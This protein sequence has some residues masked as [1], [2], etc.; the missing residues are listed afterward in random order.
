MNRYEYRLNHLRGIAWHDMLISSWQKLLIKY[1]NVYV[2]DTIKN[3]Q[4]ET[5]TIET[6]NE[7]TCQL[8]EE[9]KTV[10]VD[11]TANESIKEKS[12]KDVI[13]DKPLNNLIKGLKNLNKFY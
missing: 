6:S 5:N 10:D 4:E 2:D 7:T 11:K 12:L 8:L 3:T 1:G 13:I 9:D